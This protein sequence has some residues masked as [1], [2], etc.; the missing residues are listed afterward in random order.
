MTTVKQVYSILAASYLLILFIYFLKFYDKE[1]ARGY[2]DIL[3][4]SSSLIASIAAVYGAKR[5]W[6][7]LN[8]ILTTSWVLISLGLLLWFAAETAWIIHFDL[9]GLELTTVSYADILWLAGYPLIALGLFRY[10][11]ISVKARALMGK[12]EHILQKYGVFVS[13]TVIVGYA[14]PTTIFSMTPALDPEADLVSKIVNIAYPFMD[15]VLLAIIAPFAV[16]FL[17]GGIEKQWLPVIGG[18]TLFL[19]YDLWYAGAVFEGAYYSGHPSDLIYVFG[20]LAL[21]AGIFHQIKR[22]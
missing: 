13:L 12:T 18:V 17:T 21:A 4:I 20:D 10:Y 3:T 8:E 19:V 16:G 6:F 7:K 5:Y 14:I 1:F 2:T 15:I 22:I 9:L 11:T